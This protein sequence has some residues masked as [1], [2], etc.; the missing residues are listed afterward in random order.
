MN[1]VEPGKV[2]MTVT[3]MDGKVREFDFTPLPDVSNQTA[4]LDSILGAPNL[5]LELENRL[6]VIPM[7]NV[8]SLEFSPLPCKLPSRALR[9][10]RE[11][12]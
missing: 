1:F 4:R 5:V 10:A 8:R 11:A 9:V 2:T 7:E 12:A 6:M 3:Y